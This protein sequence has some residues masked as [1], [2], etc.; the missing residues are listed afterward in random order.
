MCDSG[1]IEN[2]EL[3]KN[4]LT[5]QFE[6]YKRSRRLYTSEKI[7]R[8]SNKI[9]NLITLKNQIITMKKCLYKLK[10]DLHKIKTVFLKSNICKQQKP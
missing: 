8:N 5:E 3:N 4:D 1:D 10:K 6:K 2:N 7:N 9:N